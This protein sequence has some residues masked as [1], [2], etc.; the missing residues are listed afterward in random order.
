MAKSKLVLIILCLFIVIL[1]FVLYYFLPNLSVPIVNAF[2]WL[3]LIMAFAF[4]SLLRIPVKQVLYLALT[5]TIVGAILSSMSFLV[6]DT[7]SEF[8]LRVSFVF[9]LVGLL[10]LY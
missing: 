9:W 6:G 5:F 1:L 4:I 3:I 8:I 7:T 2:Y 10:K